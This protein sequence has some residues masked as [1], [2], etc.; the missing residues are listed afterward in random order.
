[1]RY[2]FLA[3][4]LFFIACDNELVLIDEKK[5]IPVVFGFLSSTD[6]AQYFK[7]TRAFVD[8]EVSALTIAKNPD[9]LY[10]KN[11]DVKLLHGDNEYSLTEVDG[12]LEGYVKEEGVFA[13]SPNTLYK[14]RNSDLELVED[15]FYTLSISRGD[16]FDDIQSTTQLIP[17]PLISK[18]INDGTINFP[19]FGFARIK[20]KPEDNIPVYD[21]NIYMKIQEQDVTVPNSTFRDTTLVWNVGRNIQPGP[22]EFDVLGTSFYQ[23]LK[24]KLEENLNIRRRFV[25]LDVELVGGGVEMLNYIN[26]TSAN[27]GIT[28]SQDIPNYTNMSEG[29]GVFS[30]RNT[31]VNQNIRLSTIT[32]DSLNNGSITRNLNFL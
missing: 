12:N 28:S 16:Q 11:L 21:L 19:S 1:M 23:F 31:A 10:Y 27:L 2:L 30:S 25:T 6:T 3:I 29:L 14:I 26:V 20:W 8:P 15:D 22:N 17:E 24:S 7:I 13:Q 32:K 18:P 5:E 9:S 4:T